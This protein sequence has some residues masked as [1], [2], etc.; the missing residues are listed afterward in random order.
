M[1][2]FYSWTECLYLAKE[3]LKKTLIY[4]GAY[5]A[6]TQGLIQTI[7]TPL[8]EKSHSTILSFFLSSKP[9]EKRVCELYSLLLTDVKMKKRMFNENLKLV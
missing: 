1:N 8:K 3:R 5:T 9:S 6:I 2:Y 7:F 4:I